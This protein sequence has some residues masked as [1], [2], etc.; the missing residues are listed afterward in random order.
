[1]AEAAEN[2]LK[3]GEVSAMIRQGFI[4]SPRL[5]PTSSPPPPATATA[6]HPSPPR[7]S[8]PSPK[9]PTLFEMITHEDLARRVSSRTHPSGDQ[10]RLRLLERIAAMIAKEGPG[11]V[12]LSVSSGDGFR[13]PIA[14]HRRVLAAGSR[15]FA[16]KLAGIG[17]WPGRPVMVEICDCDDAEVYVEVV[18]L[19][20]STDLRRSLAGED[21]ERVLGL[22]KV[23]VDIKFDDAISACLDHLEAIPWSEDEEEKVMS[24]LSKLR[25]QQ[26]HESIER[27]LQRVS[28]EPSTS[29]N[30]DS[31]VVNVL[32]GVLQAKD[33]KARRD[34]KALIARLLRG[35]LNQSDIHYKNLEVPRETLYQLCHKRMDCLMLLLSEAAN[36]VEGQ[37]DRAALMGEVAREADNVQWLVDILI[38]KRIAD[39]F[40]SLWANQS[41]L[42]TCHS[43]IPCI[44]RFEISMITAQLCV[45]IGKG[46]I[47]VSKDAKVSLLR[48]WL[49]ALFEDFGW[50]KRT[51]RTFNKKM[52]EDGLSATILTLP[53]AEQQTILLRWFD[54]FL[55]KGD[56]CPNI[57][58]AFEIWWRRAFI[59][60]YAGEHDH[61]HLQ[62]VDS[63]NHI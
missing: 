40:V 57:Q 14:V 4:S 47:L 5:S 23:S 52:V 61:S 17:G 12:E 10:K 50:M 8:V 41:G 38:D 33:K 18:G 62:M 63:D 15:F 42:A 34:M 43:K 19:M 7:P 56:D 2:L 6:V 28:V 48:T 32:H 3:S 37:G 24:T 30:A 20:Y 1:M 60:Q 53:M 36:I 46:Q 26:L 29:A 59:K 35:D 9:S 31:I 51:S 58:R 44:Y 45:A 54:C 11:D 16:E 39:E 22:L 55:N 21:V 27:V 25:I 49:E 13:V